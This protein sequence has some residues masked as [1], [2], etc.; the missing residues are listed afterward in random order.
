MLSVWF[1][2]LQLFGSL[3]DCSYRHY[4]ISLTK[5]WSQCQPAVGLTHLDISGAYK[6]AHMGRGSQVEREDSLRS[7][8]PLK[9]MYLETLPHYLLSMWNSLVDYHA[10][11]IVPTCLLKLNQPE[12]HK[13]KY[14]TDFYLFI[15]LWMHVHEH[16]CGYV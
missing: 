3:S 15:R 14:N 9:H 12:V 6:W 4:T 13:I 8:L 16:V 1:E 5:H 7:H 2:L 10:Q 11:K